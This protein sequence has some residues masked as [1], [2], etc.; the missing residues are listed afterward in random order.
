MKVI[1]A[2]A[3]ILRREGIDSLS[4]FPT[5]PLIEAAAALDIRPI[6]CRQERIGV[7]I[8]DGFARVSNGRPPGAF[9]M[10]F[11]PGVENAVPG[12]TTAF[13][14]SS[15]VLLLPMGHP[16]ERDGT[17]PF[18]SAVRSLA[19]VTKSAEQIN[20]PERAVDAM[21]RAFR[22][23][24]TGRPGPALVEIPEDVAEADIEPELVDRYVPMPATRTQSDTPDVEA[25]VEAL[26]AARQP[27]IIAGAGVLYAGA[28]AELAELAEILR[29]P[30]MTTMGGKSAISEKRH[31]L[32][33][34]SGSGVMSGTVHHFLKEADV[35]LAVGTSLTRHVLVTPIPPGKRIIQVTNEPS[36]L[37]KTQ[38]VEFPILGDARLVLRQFLACRD[39]LPRPR[40][41]R[42]EAV[43]GE[44]ERVRASWLAGWMPKLASDEVPINPYRVIWDFMHEIDPARAIVTHDSG[45]PRF[46]TMPFYAS[47]GPR[48]YLGWGKSHQ[49][50]TGLG[51]A[52]GAKLAAP[53]K[54]CAVIMGDAGFGMTG[55][56]FET[57]AR[58][59][60]PICAIVLNNGTMSCETGHMAL[61]HGKYRSRDLG[62]DY[63]DI[64]RALGGWSERVVDPAEVRPAIRR[65]KRATEEGR[66][67]LL[68]FITSEEL[69]LSYLHPFG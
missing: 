51:L 55:L 28:S 18:F 54:F 9:A 60:L 49:L 58:A 59:S 3:R 67:A 30:V 21:R 65:A 64:A 15:P 56:D 22:A 25:A 47:D 53:E 36:D 2:I 11:G 40:G 35:V 41:P 32:A 34:G 13:S 42:E 7:G 8:A 16:R 31:P 38:H 24:K 48:S 50:G 57:A 62:G 46:E 69:A 39:A 5:T 26:L 43:I 68:E 10:Q 45:N 20:V 4:C 66:P 1:E 14:D 29:L 12:I 37:H 17:P 52:L 27:M 44:I 61:S 19:S 6:V 63:A 23:L 33:L